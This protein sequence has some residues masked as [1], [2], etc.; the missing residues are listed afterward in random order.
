MLA[1]GSSRGRQNR[2]QG[3]AIKAR[4][5]RC[6]EIQFGYRDPEAEKSGKPQGEAMSRRKSCQ[7]FQAKTGT[8]VTAGSGPASSPG[9]RPQTAND[10]PR[11]AQ[12]RGNTSQETSWAAPQPVANLTKRQSQGDQSPQH[13]KPT[14]PSPR[15]K[16]GV[17]ASPS[18]SNA[19]DKASPRR[20]KSS[21]VLGKHPQSSLSPKKMKVVNI[22]VPREEH[23]L[24]SREGDR[25][26]TLTEKERLALF[27]SF[28][29]VLN[30]MIGLKEQWD[31]AMEAFKGK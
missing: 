12:G 14:P 10:V 2:I 13:K 24:P 28:C 31:Q 17:D 18:V 15:R 1:R 21:S 27:S 9:V 16:S 26:S 20:D 7:D 5:P 6:Y 11:T 3:N 29:D 4:P 8:A 30:K 25:K 23:N 19:T 22:E